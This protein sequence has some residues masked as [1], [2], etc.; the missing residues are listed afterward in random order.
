MLNGEVQP[1]RGLTSYSPRVLLLAQRWGKG[2]KLTIIVR[3]N[4]AT[5]WLKRSCADF[6]KGKVPTGAGR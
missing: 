4:L 5:L 2:Q 6:K 3:Q 1:I